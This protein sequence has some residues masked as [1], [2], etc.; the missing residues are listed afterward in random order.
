MKREVVRVMGVKLVHAW[1]GIFLVMDS[2][3]HRWDRVHGL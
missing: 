1:D 3:D 2:D